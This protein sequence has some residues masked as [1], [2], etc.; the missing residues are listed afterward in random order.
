VIAGPRGP[1]TA[2]D[3]VRT[4]VLDLVVHVDDFARSLPDR[5]P[6]P[7]TRSALA[8]TTRLLAEMLATS[9]PGRSV[10]V[11]LAP[12]VAVQA[13]EGPPHKRG[14]PPNTV[15]TDPVTWLRVAT[16]RR[17]FAAAVADGSIRASGTRADL[18]AHLPLLS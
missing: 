17:D 7:L 16:G 11:R 2:R 6:P 8:D 3:F 9:A 18:T 1:I 12:Y 14:T 5:E 4:R 13:I 15:E 10:E